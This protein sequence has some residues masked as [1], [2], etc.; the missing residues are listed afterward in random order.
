MAGPLNSRMTRVLPI[1]RWLR[2]HGGATW[3]KDLLELAG[4]NRTVADPGDVE[5][6]RLDIELRVPATAERLAWM[7][8]NVRALV[9][10]EGRRWRELLKRIERDPQKRVRALN[11]LREGNTVRLPRGFVLE[12]ETNADCFV[13][14]KHAVIWVEGKR[15]DWLDPKITWDAVRDQVARNIDA[16]RTWANQHPNSIGK[17]REYYLL[18]CHEH[19]LKH[20]ETQLIQGYQ[21]C[22]WAGGLPHVSEEVRRDMSTRIMTLPWSRILDRWPA[23]RALPELADFGSL[24]I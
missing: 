7:I 22:T 18:V 6:V 8:E 21:R 11:T 24:D 15:F 5:D 19:P 9:P 12:G 16:A 1:F 17:A 10:A 14:A 20:H 4:S 13:I 23:L 2:E 3:P